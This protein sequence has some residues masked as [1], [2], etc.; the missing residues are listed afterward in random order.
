MAEWLRR[1]LQIRQIRRKTATVVAFLPPVDPGN[2]I[3]TSDRVN[4]RAGRN[5]VTLFACDRN[6]VTLSRSYRNGPK[7]HL[8]RETATVFE[9]LKIGFGIVVAIV[10]AIV[11]SQAVQAAGRTFAQVERVTQQ[12]AR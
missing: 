1:G 11:V 3:E 2:H 8:A 6:T 7:A 4:T 5:L 10:A 12:G 9:L